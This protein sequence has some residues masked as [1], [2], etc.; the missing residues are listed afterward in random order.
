MEHR[1]HGFESNSSHSSG[2]LPKTV[3]CRMGFIYTVQLTIFGLEKCTDFF[4]IQILSADNCV[5]LQKGLQSL[6]IKF[7]KLYHEANRL[8]LCS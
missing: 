8:F 1:G 6:E 4:D 3:L 2:W 7:S 5:K